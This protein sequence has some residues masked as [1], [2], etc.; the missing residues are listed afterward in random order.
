VAVN[1]L[2]FAF[3][4]TSAKLKESH[5]RLVLR[6]VYTKNITAVWLSFTGSGG[7]HRTF[8]K[9]GIA[10]MQEYVR[11]MYI[12]SRQ[13]LKNVTVNAVIFDDGTWD[14]DP[15]K[16]IKI[17]NNG[18]GEKAQ[19]DLIYSWL[20]NALQS[21]DADSFRI[22]ESVI[23]KIKAL[24]DDPGRG[25][26]DYRNGLHTGKYEMLNHLNEIKT[27][28][29]VG[30]TSLRQK[31]KVIRELYDKPIFQGQISRSQNPLP[32]IFVVYIPSH[33]GGFEFDN[34]GCGGS[35]IGILSKRK[36]EHLVA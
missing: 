13:F 3:Q 33:D 29:R 32:N 7:I 6:N 10:P 17:M 11:D 23:S 22:L 28:P 36:L 8:G 14:G 27:Q 18:R 4:I 31:L 15:E 19:L 5:F 12:P 30:I 20:Q 34:N 16:V 26:V 21:P 24:P 25:N 9:R 1:N 35:G 2:T